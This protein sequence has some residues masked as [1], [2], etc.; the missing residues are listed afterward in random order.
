[1]DPLS[2]V[3]QSLSPYNYCLN[4]PVVYVDPDG[5]NPIVTGIIGGLVSVGVSYAYTKLSTEDEWEWKSDGISSFS[6]GFMIGSGTA[7]LTGLGY[8][9]IK[10]L[11]YEAINT[12]IGA[13]MESSLKSSFE[14]DFSYLETSSDMVIGLLTGSFRS[15]MD[16][17][18]KEFMNKYG[19]K[20]IES[21]TKSQFNEYLDI[22]EK[23]WKAQITSKG[24]K[25]GGKEFKKQLGKLM[26]QSRDFKLSEIESVKGAVKVTGSKINDISLES[27]QQYTDEKTFEK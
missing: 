9:T 25:S 2:D 15:K 6:G 11:G 18:I 26:N 16:F 1:V 19:D 23:Y 8:S 10:I 22:Q 5:K 3:Y 17:G 4:R 13:G 24:I 21:L 20:T 12:A 7:L 14:H 27:L